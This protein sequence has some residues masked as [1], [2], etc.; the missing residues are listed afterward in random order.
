M[1]QI[2]DLKCISREPRTVVAILTSVRI[3]WATDIHLDFAG[4]KAVDRFIASVVEVQPDCLILTGDTGE[5]DSWRLLLDNLT[6]RVGKPVYFVLGNHDYYRSTIAKVRCEASSVPGW[7]VKSGALLLSDEVALVG[8]DGW[9]DG[10]LGNYASSNVML[11]DYLLIGE[12]VHANRF[13]RLRV[14]EALGDEA[15][16]AM[17]GCVRTLRCSPGARSTGFRNC[18]GC[19]RFS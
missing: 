4:K 15:A 9:G 10:R 18:S 17:C 7:L 14:L 8:H 16:A 3:A 6:E 1:A 11:N 19:L 5:S 12:L 2:I 13:A